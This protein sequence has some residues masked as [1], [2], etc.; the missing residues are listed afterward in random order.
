MEHDTISNNSVVLSEIFPP[1]F[2]LLCI[3]F[4]FRN[5]LFLLEEKQCTDQ[6][7]FRKH[8]GASNVVIPQGYKKQ[9]RKHLNGGA[10]HVGS[11]P[12]LGH[13]TLL[14]EATV[15]PLSTQDSDTVSSVSKKLF[16]G[17]RRVLVSI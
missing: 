4:P 8:F 16:P 5:F 15:T 13:C 9:I 17:D 11:W 7:F 14:R 10:A 6:F 2:K 12:V 3:H 1:S